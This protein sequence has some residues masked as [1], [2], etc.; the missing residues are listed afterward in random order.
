[1]EPGGFKLWIN[2]IATCTAP[3]RG[4]R[5]AG[6]GVAELDRLVRDLRAAVLDVDGDGAVGD[7]GAGC[8]GGCHVVVVQIE[9][10]TTFIVSKLH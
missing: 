4:G 7:S 6:G 5:G 2:W 8:D 9:L 1:L 10:Y 3:H